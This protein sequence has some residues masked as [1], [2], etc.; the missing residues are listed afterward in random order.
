M[1]SLLATHTRGDVAN[2]ICQ[3]QESQTHNA[4]T[5]ADHLVQRTYLAALLRPG[6]AGGLYFWT[7]RV[8][9]GAGYEAVAAAFCGTPEFK[10]RYDAM[11]NP[12]FVQ[13]LYNNTLG[14]DGDP[15]GTAFWNAQLAQGRPRSIV[16]LQFAD[17]TEFKQRTGI[18]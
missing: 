5:I 6:D 3:S 9:D 14:R 4:A 15:D 7:K 18:S 13:A 10:N 1:V 12:T 16:V 2:F 8:W 17:S 11:D